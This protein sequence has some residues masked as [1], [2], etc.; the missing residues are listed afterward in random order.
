MSLNFMYLKKH[1]KLLEILRFCCPLMF[2]SE[3]V[4]AEIPYNLNII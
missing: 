1:Y 4:V 3:P 2:V